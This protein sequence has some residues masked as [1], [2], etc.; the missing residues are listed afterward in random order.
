[1]SDLEGR[2]LEMRSLQLQS[3][4]EL[5]C[6]RKNENIKIIIKGEMKASS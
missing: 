5:I 2:P 1:M 6:A 4:T 3:Q